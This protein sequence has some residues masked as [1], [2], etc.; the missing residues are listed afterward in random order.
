[1][2]ANCTE[3]FIDLEKADE[4]RM[5]EKTPKDRIAQL[6]TAAHQMR[7]FTALHHN[8]LFMLASG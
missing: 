5:K 2:R 4:P 3:G 7:V 6:L 8:P 1:L